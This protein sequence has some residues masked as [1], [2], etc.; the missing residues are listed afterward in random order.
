MISQLNNILGEWVQFII[1]V[2]LGCNAPH[3]HARGAEPVFS[4]LQKS[5]R[6]FERNDGMHYRAIGT[7]S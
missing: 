2:R 6:C 4:F 1:Y 5:I 3:T 7:G